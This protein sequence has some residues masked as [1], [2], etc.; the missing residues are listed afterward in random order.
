MI[1]KHFVVSQKKGWEEPKFCVN[2]ICTLTTLEKKK[3]DLDGHM[4]KPT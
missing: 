1:Q 4:E 2:Y 3:I